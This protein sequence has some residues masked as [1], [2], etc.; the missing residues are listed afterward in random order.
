MSGPLIRHRFTAFGGSAC[1]VLV[2]DGSQT[3]VSALVA[4]VYAFEAQL[5][6]FDPA[7]ELSRFNRAAGTRQPVSWLLKALLDACLKAF[8]LS[9]GL[10]NAAVHNAVVA[11]GYDRSIAE[12]RI[13]PGPM[14][15]NPIAVPQLPEILDVGPG[16]ARISPGH[17][18]DL[19]G[20]GKGWLADQLCERFDNAC[21]NLGGDL[22]ALGDGPDGLGWVVG[23]GDGRSISVRDG[24]VATSGTNNRSWPG[25]HHLID[26]RTGRPA[27]TGAMAVSV[28]GRDAF[29]AEVLAK[30]AVIVGAAGAA[31]WLVD[32]G[33]ADHFVIWS[34]QSRLAS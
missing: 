16:W 28:A 12:V 34:E 23:L 30:S 29:T 25:G 14:A 13:H 20:V 22:R 3:D 5:T 11:A 6:R 26:P 10:V 1:E 27:G 24:G 4:E 17:A 31:A 21:V 33:V 7:S 32:H 9:D 18:I 15:G 19:G 8:V 2:V